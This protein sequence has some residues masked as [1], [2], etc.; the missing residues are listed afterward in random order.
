MGLRHLT[1]RVLVVLT[2]MVLL[3]GCGSGAAT[4]PVTTPTPTALPTAAATPAA[5]PV[6]TASPTST[7]KPTPTPEPV[8]G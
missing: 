7:A 6:P 1:T 8:A 3:G 5:S 4:P 2:I